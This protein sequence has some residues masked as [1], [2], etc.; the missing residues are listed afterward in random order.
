MG[1]E[2][3]VSEP[4]CRTI[5]YS[6]TNQKNNLVSLK[7]IDSNSQCVFFVIIAFKHSSLTRKL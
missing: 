7:N 4:T 6:Q 2:Y 5:R 3:Q 1:C